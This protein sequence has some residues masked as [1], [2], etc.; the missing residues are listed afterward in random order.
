MPWLDVLW[1]EISRVF[2]AL[3]LDGGRL[4]GM[5]ACFTAPEGYS[6]STS[7]ELAHRGNAANTCRVHQ[8]TIDFVPRRNADT[9]ARNAGHQ[10]AWSMVRLPVARS[11][12]SFVAGVCATDQSVRDGAAPRND[13]TEQTSAWSHTPS[14]NAGACIGRREYGN[15]KCG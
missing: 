12:R 13:H 14:A 15:V 9:P 4:E 10:H 7:C 11:S 6:L 2:G 5:C 3:A 8:Y 1:R